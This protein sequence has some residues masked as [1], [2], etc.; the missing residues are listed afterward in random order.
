[1]CVCAK[2]NYKE[3]ETKN[4]RKYFVRDPRPHIYYAYLLLELY[5]CWILIAFVFVI[6]TRVTCLFSYIY[7]HTYISIYTPCASPHIL[8]LCA[9]FTCLHGAWE[10]NESNFYNIHIKIYNIYIW[11]NNNNNAMRYEKKRLL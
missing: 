4:T 10:Q 2:E 6:V 7:I 5:S 8:Y 3:G 9:T 11:Y 1:M